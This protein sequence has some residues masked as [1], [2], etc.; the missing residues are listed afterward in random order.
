MSD[1]RTKTPRFHWEPSSALCPSCRAT[2][3]VL[4]S[5]RNGTL[6]ACSCPNCSYAVEFG[7]F[8]DEL[9]FPGDWTSIPKPPRSPTFSPA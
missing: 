2:T 6:M 1:P 4:I 5:N 9:H 8:K 3:N 7:T